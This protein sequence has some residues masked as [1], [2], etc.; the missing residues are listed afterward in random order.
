MQNVTEEPLNVYYSPR[1]CLETMIH[2]AL[3]THF[4]KHVKLNACNDLSWLIRKLRHKEKIPHYRPH[5]EQLHG[6]GSRQANS[7]LNHLISPEQTAQRI[8]PEESQAWFVG[9]VTRY[10]RKKPRNEARAISRG[11]DV[12]KGV[13]GFMKVIILVHKVIAVHYW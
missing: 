11:Q 2:S 4:W 3:N 6:L 5:W 10:D 1:E 12:T 8:L 9:W 7:T 13:T